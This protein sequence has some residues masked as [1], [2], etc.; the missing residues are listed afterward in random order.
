MAGNIKRCQECGALGLRQWDIQ[1]RG[2]LLSVSRKVNTVIPHDPTI[3]LLLHPH[4]GLDRQTHTGMCMAVL[5]EDRKTNVVTSHKGTLDSNQNE[6]T[7][8]TCMDAFHKHNV[9][10][11]KQETKEYIMHDHI[12]IK[13]RGHPWWSSGQD[14]SF[15]VQG[16]QVWSLVR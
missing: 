5:A 10:G 12:N 14:F 9:E 7:A 4:G 11:Q 8:H 2:K 15:P 16:A 1:T 3:P 13:L 6:W